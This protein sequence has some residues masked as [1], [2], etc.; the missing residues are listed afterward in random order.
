ML[1]WGMFSFSEFTVVLG[2]IVD[3]CMAVLLIL[4]VALGLATTHTLYLFVGMSFLFLSVAFASLFTR[5]MV[6]GWVDLD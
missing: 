3:D 4:E 6:L 2:A 5:G 1:P